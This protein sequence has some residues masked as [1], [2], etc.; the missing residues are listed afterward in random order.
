MSAF[1]NF[2]QTLLAQKMYQT[3]IKY[4]HWLSCET[5]YESYKFLRR[6]LIFFSCTKYIQLKAMTNFILN[7]FWQGFPHCRL[8]FNLPPRTNWHR[9]KYCAVCKQRF[10]DLGSRAFFSQ[11]HW[12]SVSHSFTC[13]RLRTYV[14]TFILRYTCHV[15][16]LCLFFSVRNGFC[17]FATFV[18]C[19]HTYYV[20]QR[21]HK[22]LKSVNYWINNI[23]DVYNKVRKRKTKR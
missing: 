20:Y 5:N 1:D 7:D 3:Y 9:L 19:S 11:N 4:Y 22:W 6:Y 10:R 8:E 12:L 14:F 18:Q 23:F 17:H 2:N 13:A 16:C 15:R 21:A